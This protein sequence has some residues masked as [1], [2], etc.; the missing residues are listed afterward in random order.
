[1]FDAIRTAR[2]AATNFIADKGWAAYQKAALSV[3]VTNFRDMDE[4]QALA[5]CKAC[6]HGQMFASAKASGETPTPTISKAQ[7]FS[8]MAHAFYNDKEAATGEPVDIDPTKIYANYNR[9]SPQTKTARA[10][11]S[12]P[13]AEDA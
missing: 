8:D 11:A 13:Q 2:V 12:K 6:G 9:L 1:M 10:A 4:D 7:A 3:G 5:L